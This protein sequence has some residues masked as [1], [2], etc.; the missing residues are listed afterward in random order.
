MPS[1]MV[2]VHAKDLGAY[3]LDLT[4]AYDQ[5]DWG[6]LE[7]TMRQLGFQSSWIQWTMECVTTVRYSVCQNNVSL[8]PF[9]PSRGL[10]QGDPLLPYLFLFVVD[11]L[12]KLLQHEV[13]RDVLKELHVSRHSPS[14]S[15]LL[16][17]DD[18]MLFM[19]VSEEQTVAV[20]QTLRCYEQCMRQLINL[21][22][23]SLMF[24]VDFTQQAKDR[25]AEIL[26]VSNVAVEEKYLGLPTLQGHMDKNKFKSTKERLSKRFLSWVEW[27][28]SL[29]AKEVL[30]KSIAQAIA[31]YVMGIFKLPSMLCEEM[32]QMIRYFW[33]GEEK[34]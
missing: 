32:E 13:D 23:C 21:G 5:V 31:T 22:K 34:G 12:S 26:Q 7:K 24:G 29:G 3:K 10:H 11:E 27:Y 19:D 6:F 33:W 9:Y 15:H 4:K 2:A 14:I 16:F 1:N 18:T 28:M 20:N 17:A 8:E 25:V 30:I